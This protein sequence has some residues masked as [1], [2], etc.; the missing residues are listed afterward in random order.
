MGLLAVIKEPTVIED[1]LLDSLGEGRNDRSKENYVFVTREMIRHARLSRGPPSPRSPFRLSS[2][3]SL[4]FLSLSLSS[5]PSHS[6]SS[7]NVSFTYLIGKS[8]DK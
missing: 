1:L 4:S 6:L 8:A 2:F 3:S 7:V 5:R